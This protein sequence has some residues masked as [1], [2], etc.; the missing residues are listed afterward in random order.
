MNLGKVDVRVRA[1]LPFIGFIANRVAQTLRL[2]RMYSL[3][4]KLK[5]SKIIYRIPSTKS[6]D[7]DFRM[8]LN[9]YFIHNSDIKQKIT[10]S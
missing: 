8:G 6:I 3:L 9:I 2:M 1:R 7:N 10:S 4:G 5:R